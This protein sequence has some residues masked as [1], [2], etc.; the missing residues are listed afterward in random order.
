M[1]PQPMIPIRRGAVTSTSEPERSP[2]TRPGP[3]ERVR[4]AARCGSMAQA[5]PGC[6]GPTDLRSP[7]LLPRLGNHPG[8]D[9]GDSLKRWN[10]RAMGMVYQCMMETSC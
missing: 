7:R 8:E 10:P 9:P 4:T 5:A 3:L 2:A 6:Q 1:R